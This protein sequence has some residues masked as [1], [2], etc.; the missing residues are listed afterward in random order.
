MDLESTC[1]GDFVSWSLMGITG[2]TRHFTGVLSNL[3]NSPDP[4]GRFK[5]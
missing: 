2:A 3:T 4:A 1:Q 5:V